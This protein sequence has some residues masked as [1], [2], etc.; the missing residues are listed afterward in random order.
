MSAPL[1]ELLAKVG[2]TIRIAPPGEGVIGMLKREASETMI[3]LA[4]G[5]DEAA[6]DTIA[7]YLIARLLDITLPPLPAELEITEL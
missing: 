1:P 4:S 3:W 6:R 7:R 2:V 5:W